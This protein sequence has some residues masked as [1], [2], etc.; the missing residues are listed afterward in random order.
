MNATITLKEY[1]N[2][3]KPFIIPNYQ[4][5][6][7]WGKNKIDEK[8]SVTY[9]LQTILQGYK[10]NSEIFLQGITVSEQQDKII[11]VDGQQRTTCLFLLLKYLGYTD[12][13]VIEY[14][15]REESNEFLQNVHLDKIEKDKAEKFQDIYFF[16]KT[17]RTIKERM[18]EIE[19]QKEKEQ[20]LAYILQKIK[21]L[22]INIPHPNQAMKVFNMMNGNKA[23]MKTEEIIKAEILRLV[24]LGNAT[25]VNDPKNEHA[26]EWENNMLRSRYAREWDKWLYWWNREEV[27]KLFKCSN[28]MGLLISTYANKNETKLTF[29][30]FKEQFLKGSNPKKAK[31]IFDG[32]RR[33]Q[34]R[35]E[36]AFNDPET[37]NMTGAILRIFKPEDRAKFIEYYFKDDHRLHL[38]E[39]YK[40]IFL[41]MNHKEIIDY[42]DKKDLSVFDSKYEIMLN[43]IREDFAYTNISNKDEINC[44]EWAFR[45]L[46]R[47]N[48]DED[49]KQQQQDAMKGRKFDFSI[50][51]NGNRSLEHIHP[52]SKVWHLNDEKEIVDGNG[53]PV[54][55]NDTYL[56]REDIK[57]GDEKTTE[58]S[59]GNL[60][61]LYKKENSA[62][63]NH[64]FE[65]KKA[66]FFDPGNKEY[67][68]SRH[69][70]HTIY[71]FAKS[72]WTGED[73][74]ETKKNIITNFEKYYGKQD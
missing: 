29:E 35:F 30:W 41:D 3:N 21:F 49:R 5:G 61:L 64:S 48:I 27:Q 72:Q 51:E 1:L 73:I 32:L 42:I 44:K 38:S 16:K 55:P 69:L 68:N 12:T 33:L 23:Q 37:Y 70:L 60:V 45:L 40:L 24:S 62:F 34:K 11:I 10:S 4:R 52:K 9:L 56:C 17:L 54:I 67:F 15:I 59:I 13:F 47:L 31:D 26:N 36:D 53:N 20:F 8:D 50:W 65:K 43:A 18:E 46:L 39:Y 6:Y 2:K 57:H 74:A 63:S 28:T 66:M 71:A 22:Y 7:I 14:E 25:G 19:K 58:H